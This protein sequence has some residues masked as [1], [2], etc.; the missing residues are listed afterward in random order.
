MKTDDVVQRDGKTY[1][2]CPDHKH[3]QGYYNG[4][5]VTSHKPC[6]HKK[7]IESGKKYIKYD[8]NP[9]DSSNPPGNKTSESSDKLSLKNSLKEVLATQYMMSDSDIENIWKSTL[10]N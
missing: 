6:D 8:S 1:Y 9:S 5:Y 2:W 10:G 4:L 3:P 7:W